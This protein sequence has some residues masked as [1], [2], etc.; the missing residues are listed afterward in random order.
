VPPVHHAAEH[1][2]LARRDTAAESGH[3]AGAALVAVGIEE[4]GVELAE[5]VD[6]P[7]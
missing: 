3:E 1:E 4:A 6:F 2:V 5:A 7:R